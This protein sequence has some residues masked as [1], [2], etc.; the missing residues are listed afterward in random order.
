MK[1]RWRC[2]GRNIM[3][4]TVLPTILVVFSILLLQIW[5]A[6]A[7]V[8]SGYRE[9]IFA[10]A[11]GNLDGWLDEAELQR[12]YFRDQLPLTPGYSSLA[13]NFNISDSP[14]VALD[15]WIA[16]FG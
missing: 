13:N 6:C 8:S 1:I 10:R 11:D 9:E 5:V 14:S 3:E 2:E 12:E 7:Q 15:A 16:R 4:K